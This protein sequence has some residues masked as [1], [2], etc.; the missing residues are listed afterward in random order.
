MEIKPQSSQEQITKN[1]LDMLEEATEDDIE[2]IVKKLKQTKQ[3]ESTE[4]R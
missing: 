4:Y 2:K 3:P 1:R